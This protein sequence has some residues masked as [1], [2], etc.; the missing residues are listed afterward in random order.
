MGKGAIG[1]G[2]TALLVLAPA[3]ALADQVINA[4]PQNR[5]TTPDVT[6]AQGERLSF[7]NN[8]IATHDVASDA[9][10]PD[11]SP[12]FKSDPAAFGQTKFVEGSQY[13]R[14]GTYTFYCSFHS[15][16]KGTLHVSSAGT[17]APRPDHTAP[18][19]RIGITATKLSTV[20]ATRKLPVAVSVD[21]TATIKLTATAKKG[22]RTIKLGTPLSF[23]RSAGRAKTVTITISRAAAAQLGG[24]GPITF[25]VVGSA[26]DSAGNSG[27]KRATKTLRG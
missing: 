2:L 1:T 13:L 14:T 18:E 11:G 24:R 27:G 26:R 23:R 15:F 3:T 17:P 5:Y 25:T 4:A 21:E 7:S 20:R 19:L 8:D 9:T 16:M 10:N 12:L 22:S 6:I